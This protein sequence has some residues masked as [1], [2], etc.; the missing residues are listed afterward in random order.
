MAL[1]FYLAFLGAASAF[2]LVDWR[3]AWFFVAL[4]GVLQ[5]PVRKLS[6]GTPVLVSFLVVGLYACIV[7]GAR[8]AILAHLTDFARRFGQLYTAI[9][10]FILLLVIS[11]FNGLFTYGFDKWKVPLVSFF[12]YCVPLVAVIVG[13]AWFQRE[14]MMYR[15]FR[16]YAAVTSVAL[17]G[18]VAEYAR[19]NSRV[20]GLVAYEGDYIRHLPGIQIRLLS[21]LYRGPDIMA[22]HAGMLTVIA[23]GMALRKGFGRSMLLWGG[24]AA[25]GFFNCMISGRR[26]AIYFVLAFTLLFVWR[27]VKR[28]GSGQIVALLGVLLL[29]GGVIQHFTRAEDTSVYAKGAVASRV[30]LAQRLEGGALE[31]LSQYGL[32]GAGLGAATQGVHHL[33]GDQQMVGWQEGGLG[34]L[35]IEVGL[36]GMLAIALIGWI[37][38]RLL[39]RLTSIDDVPGS[40]HFIRAMLFGMAGAN[41]AAFMASA[42]AFSDA[43][44]ALTAGF[45]VGCLF[46]TAALDE[47]L[48]AEERAKAAPQLTS[49]VPA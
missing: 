32:M 15:F 9:F 44:L 35:A 23:I 13:Y 47:R 24:V 38:I 10:A 17:L 39:L 22:W 21:G 25:W 48:A 6:A 11:A 27:S 19:V 7:F 3:R 45:F 26:K 18:T 16:F 40:S 4:C 36:P 28:I 29:L 14:E 43:V 5:D 1:A 34:K 30:E 31:T 12:T 42:Q 33:I 37:V 46:A 8:H 49:P 2:A 20:L 41:G